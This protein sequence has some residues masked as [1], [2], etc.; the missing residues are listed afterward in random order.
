MNRTPCLRLFLLVSLLA[1]T[2]FAAEKLDLDL[3]TPVPA[4]QPIPTQDFFRPSALSRPQLNRSGTHIAAIVSFGED[5]QQLLI[6]EIATGKINTLGSSQEKD[7]YGLAWLDDSRV[8]F[9]ISSRK[10]WGLGILAADIDN[11][12]K[13]YPVQQYSGSVLVSIPLKNPLH[14][15]IWNRN[16]IDNHHDNGVVEV[17]T[18]RQAGK[19]VDLLSTATNYGEA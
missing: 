19:F 5:K 1:Q 18:S 17:N 14:P 11:L 9:H 4:D 8:L 13:A 12:S 16:D 6:Y 7:V 2:V 10:L 15:L 3:E